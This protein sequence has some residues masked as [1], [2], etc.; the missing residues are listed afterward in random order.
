MPKGRSVNTKEIFE[1][2]DDKCGKVCKNNKS[3]RVVQGNWTDLVCMCCSNEN[4]GPVLQ[5]T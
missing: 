4:N 1:K 3:K 2:A 5:N